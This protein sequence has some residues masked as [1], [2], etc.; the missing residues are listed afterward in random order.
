MDRAAFT[1][2]APGEPVAI[3]DGETTFVPAPLKPNFEITPGIQRLVAD[4]RQA[5]GRLDGIGRLLSNPQVLIGSLQRRE[6]LRSSSL[7]GTFATP[8]ELLRAEAEVL[9]D[10]N[11]SVERR[12][13]AREV[14]NYVQALRNAIEGRLPLSF[15]LLR[16][17][18]HTLLTGTR[19]SAKAPGEFRKGQVF[20]GVNKRFVPPPYLHL[21]SCLDAFESYLHLEDDTTDPLVRSLLAHYQFETI[22]PFRDGNG[23]VGRALLALMIQRECRM[24]QP[25]L[26]LSPY[27]E[28]NRSEY[29][30]RLFQV[31]ASADWTGWLEFCLVGSIDQADDAT[32]RC[33]GLLKARKLYDDKLQIRGASIRMNQVLDAL[34]SFPITSIPD[35][36][37]LI[38]VSY[39]TA[40]KDVD[41]LQE[42]GILSKIADAK[43]PQRFM[44]R[45]LIELMFMDIEK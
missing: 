1:E 22:H 14:A 3:E 31:S 24:E 21:Q 37:K 18:H 35:V 20:I 34:F 15:R 39:P 17:M 9:A 45:Q 8:E 44:A 13:D 30:D 36:Q 27:F 16:D 43:Q 7:E 29:V 4:S 32:K 10:G 38:N 11:V 2:N 42:L 28:A 12:D 25:L 5:L 23:R 41:V 40:K 6:A 33:D 26:Y 19:G